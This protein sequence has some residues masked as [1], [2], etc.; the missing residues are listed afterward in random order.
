MR[1]DITAVYSKREKTVLAILVLR[2]HIGSDGVIR[3]VHHGGHTPSSLIIK[4]SVSKPVV[5]GG[6]GVGDCEYE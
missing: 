5:V 1:Y 3:A 4:D 2:L 6:P